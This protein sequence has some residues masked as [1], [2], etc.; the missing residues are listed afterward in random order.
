MRILKIL[1][2][3][4]WGCQYQYF[5]TLFRWFRLFCYENFEVFILNIL[6]SLTRVFW[7]FCFRYFHI[8]LLWTS[9]CWYF[10]FLTL[11]QVL[12]IIFQTNKIL[13]PRV[14]YILFRCFNF[15]FYFRFFGS[16]YFFNILRSYLYQLAIL[17][18]VFSLHQLTMFVYHFSLVVSFGRLFIFPSSSLVAKV[19]GTETLSAYVTERTSFWLRTGV[20]MQ[21]LSTFY[22]RDSQNRIKDLK[23]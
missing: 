9:I 1:S 14:H 2:R 5:V 23:K 12:V 11:L 17:H 7:G 6:R 21:R 15:G 8:L 19:K 18:N 22:Y 4:C 20:L 10:G 13:T 3:G 16:C